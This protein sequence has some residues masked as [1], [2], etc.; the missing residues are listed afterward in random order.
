MDLFK[1]FRN[2]KRLDELIKDLNNDLL[3]LGFE[4]LMELT[5]F[6]N[7]G[8]DDKG[9]WVKSTFK[10]DDGKIIMVTVTRNHNF[11]DEL[12]NNET[13]SSDI[14]FLESELDKAVESQ[15]FEKAVK[16]RDR[17]QHLKSNEKVL[18]VFEKEL[19]NAI[20]EQNF[21]KCID[22]R[23]KIKSIKTK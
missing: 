23:D 1:Y 22:L 13:S 12:S 10:S 20:K 8:F 14:R 18:E 21:E 4:P 7:S 19:E 11:N 17:I 2:N 6:N 15:N 16:L 3:G 5:T 9:E